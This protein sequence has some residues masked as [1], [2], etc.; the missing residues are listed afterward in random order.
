VNGKDGVEKSFEMKR[1]EN[2]DSDRIRP[3]SNGVNIEVNPSEP[4]NFYNIVDR[5]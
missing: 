4:N 2:E 5:A 1:R 3:E